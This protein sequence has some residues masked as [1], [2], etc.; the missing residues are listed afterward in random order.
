MAINPAIVISACDRPESLSRLL[1]SVAN[2][3]YE[4]GEI[5]LVIS[6]DK[7][8]TSEVISIAENFEWKHGQKQIIISTEKL[9]LKKHI[10]KCGDLSEKFGAI[11]ML[12]D[13]LAVSPHFYSYA[14]KALV[15]YYDDKKVSGISLYNYQVA[16]SCF[17][18]FQAV[19]DNSDVYFM[20]V[21]S[22]WGQLFTR[23]QWTGFRNWLVAHPS[24]PDRP[25]LPAYIHQWGENSWKKHFINYLIDTDT[26]FVFPRLSLTTNFEE[27]GTNSDT[28][29]IFQVPLQVSSKSYQFKTPESSGSVYDAWFELLPHCLN[30]YQENLKNYDYAVDLYGVKKVE[31]LKCNY[32]LTSK[33]SDKALLSF[34]SELRPLEMNVMLNH[35]GQE[36]ALYQIK[37]NLFKD[38]KLNLVN[39]LEEKIKKNENGISVL[40]PAETISETQ[41]TKTL[42]SIAAQSFENKECILIS[43]GVLSGE[44]RKTIQDLNFPVRILCMQEDG[45]L[46]KL[47]VLGIRNARKGIISWIKPGDEYAKDAFQ[48]IGSVFTSNLNICWLSGVDEKFEKAGDYD[49][50]N[51]RP[52]RLNGGESYKRLS[53]GRL[54]PELELNFFR[55]HCLENFLASSGSFNDLFFDLISVYQRIVIV[56]SLGCKASAGSPLSPTEKKRLLEKYEHLK[57]KNNTALIFVDLLLRKG[58]AWTDLGEWFYTSFN[59][60]PPVLRKDPV[61]HTFY[62]SKR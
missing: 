38:A 39:L 20:Q 19:D 31:E 50:L 5:T 56:A 6:I 40:L 59:N 10:L 43:A 12:E 52:Y 9:G 2:S 13:D 30:R 51:V 8:D 17:Y 16:E 23:E 33:K 61:H 24:L 62:S 1:S 48:T 58:F 21:A 28:E 60:F 14:T 25:D 27:P 37:N 3:L 15:Y 44:L 42:R 35:E 22:S 32:I 55:R 53:D 41:I 4:E 11:I 47:I 49:L 29:N 36:I 7:S 46:E 45:N 34:G 18:P 54:L 26:Y 57:P